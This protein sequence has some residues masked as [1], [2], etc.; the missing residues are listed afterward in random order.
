MQVGVKII[1]EVGMLEWIYYMRTRVPPDL[2]HKKAQSA[3]QS[4]RY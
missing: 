2:F 3:H 1:K 4:P